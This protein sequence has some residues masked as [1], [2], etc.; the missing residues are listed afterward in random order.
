MRRSLPLSLLILCALAANAEDYPHGRLSS[1]VTPLRYELT[2]NI[3]PRQGAFG[4]NARIDVQIAAPAQ[5]IWLHGLGAD[6]HDLPEHRAK[7]VTRLG[8][9]LR[10]RCERNQCK[11]SSSDSNQRAAF[12]EGLLK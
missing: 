7:R 10:L 5:R 12:H 1:V 9:G 8:I 3:D 11:G 6:G 2:F 4:G